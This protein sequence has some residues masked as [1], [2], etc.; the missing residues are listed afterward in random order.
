[1]A[2]EKN[3]ENEDQQADGDSNTEVYVPPGMSDEDFNRYMTVDNDLSTEADVDLSEI[4]GARQS[5]DQQHGD[6]SD[7]DDED[8]GDENEVGT[9]V[10]LAAIIQSLSIVRCY[11][12]QKGC[13]S[14]EPLYHHSPRVLSIGSRF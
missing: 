12:K 1:M 9:I 5:A 10:S 8:D 13:S 14:Y 11:M 4:V 6:C 2:E 3:E 7:D